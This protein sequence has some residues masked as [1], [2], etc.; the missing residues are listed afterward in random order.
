M[1][2]WL[3]TLTTAALLLSNAACAAE[4]VSTDKQPSLAYLEKWVGKYPTLDGTTF[5][6]YPSG[7]TFWDDSNVQAALKRTLAPRVIKTLTTEWDGNSVE[8]PIT[9]QDSVLMV[10]LCK[11]H[12][13]SFDAA[14][15]YLDLKTGMVQACWTEYDAKKK[16]SFDYW[17][18][19]KAKRL[20]ENACGKNEGMK[21][22][23]VFGEA[24]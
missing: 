9:K 23:K 21:A 13:C 1:R 14:T 17:L 12:S 15:V 7:Q 18:G 16:K 5:E 24:G 11:Q 19:R 3:L 10:Y 6:H 8:H 22:Y 2:P 4:K 20:E